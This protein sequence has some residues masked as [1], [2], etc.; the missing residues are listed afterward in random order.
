MIPDQ[1]APTITVHIADRREVGS[2]ET[3]G[4]GLKPTEPA[5]RVPEHAEHS[6]VV[7]PV[8]I[9]VIPD[10]IAPTITIHIGE[11]TSEAS[12]QRRSGV[13]PKSGSSVR[14]REVASATK[15]TATLGSREGD[16]RA[17]RAR[18]SELNVDVGVAAVAHHARSRDGAQHVGGAYMRAVRRWTVEVTNPQ[19]AA[20]VEVQTEAALRHVTRRNGTGG[21]STNRSSGRVV[22]ASCR[23]TRNV[24]RGQVERRHRTVGSALAV[25]PLADVPSL[26]LGKRH[27]Q[28]CRVRERRFGSQGERT[29]RHEDERE[30]LRDTLSHALGVI[31]ATAMMRCLARCIPVVSRS[32]CHPSF[33][34]LSKVAVA[35]MTSC[36]S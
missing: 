26:A 31:A 32:R 35:L 11:V 27:L 36:A 6:T 19:G 14:V 3:I 34:S 23:A 2:A 21:R 13:L 15:C 18:R 33:L 5:R 10:Q 8:P 7:R 4:D 16:P 29:C 25:V 28:L 12:R 9:G 24:A 17:A 30:Q 20:K 1:I 22:S